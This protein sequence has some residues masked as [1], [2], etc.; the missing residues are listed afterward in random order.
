MGVHSKE[1]NEEF[2]AD[3]MFSFRHNNIRNGTY[4]WND[5]SLYNKCVYDTHQRFYWTLESV[6]ALLNVYFRVFK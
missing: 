3:I 5:F 4:V 6:D 1:W 2:R